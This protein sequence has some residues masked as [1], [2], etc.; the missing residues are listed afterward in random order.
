MHKFIY[1][2]IFVLC[3]IPLD[4]DGTLPVLFNQYSIRR[5]RDCFSEEGEQPGGE[6]PHLLVNLLKPLLLVTAQR[7]RLLMRVAD[8][9]SPPVCAGLT[10]PEG[11][12]RCCLS[13]S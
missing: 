7:M 6:A 11:G 2:N 12:Q 4:C 8:V 3:Y 10:D 5:L 1:T 13:D 9:S